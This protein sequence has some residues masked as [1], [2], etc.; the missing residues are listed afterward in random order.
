[1]LIFWKQ[2]LAFLAVP[3]TGTTAYAQALMP[4][5]S[6]SIQAPPELKHATLTRYN[7]F[8]RPMY[9]IVCSTQLDT[10]AVIR[11]PISWMRSWYRY[12][13][14]PFL[15]GKPASTQGISFDTFVSEYL[16]PTPPAYAHIGSQAR[17]IMPR[18]GTPPITYLFRYE[19]QARLRAFLEHRLETRI[20]V[21]Q[22][23]AS[24]RVKLIGR[25][26]TRS[27]KETPN[28]L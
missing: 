1:M 6:L 4:M 7:R 12:R 28:R 8:I 16:Q 3:K 2:K 18:S 23:L 19:N 22:R 26:C 17:F 5:A 13:Q 11:E 10:M 27:R 21:P 9:D 15:N 20:E 24:N 25:C 14:R